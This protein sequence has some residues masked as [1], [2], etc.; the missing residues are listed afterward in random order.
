MESP[1]T[2]A[3]DSLM[4]L[5]LAAATEQA[6]SAEARAATAAAEAAEAQRLLTRAQTAA[7]RHATEAA[8][9]RC[10]VVRSSGFK[11]SYLIQSLTLTICNTTG[12]S[13]IG[14]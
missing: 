7:Q 8:A 9:M 12:K 1:P 13:R 4:L 5:Q 2:V 11:L 14:F 3:S 6:R 10:A